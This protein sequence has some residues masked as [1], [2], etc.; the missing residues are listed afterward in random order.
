MSEKV[1]LSYRPETYWPEA[2]DQEQL[3]ARIKGERRRVIARE[4]LAKD[5]FAGLDP[6]LASEELDE[7]DRKHWGLLHPHCTGGEYL[8]GLGLAEVEI[9]RISLASTTADQISIRAVHAGEKIRYSVCDDEQ[10][11]RPHNEADTLVA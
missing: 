9:A 8:P 1:G 6:F 3:L 5:G 7:G 4:A 10:P 11:D 2:L